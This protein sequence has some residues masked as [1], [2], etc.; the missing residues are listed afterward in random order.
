VLAIVRAEIP[1]IPT[2]K[3]AVTGRF[4]L[5][6]WP[7]LL[8]AA[9]YLLTLG[10]TVHGR[11]FRTPEAV[12]VLTA[13]AVWAMVGFATLAVILASGGIAAAWHA[14]RP[15]RGGAWDAVPRPAAVDVA[16]TGAA[17]NQSA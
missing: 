12:L 7:H 3:E 2:A 10:Y 14:R 8:L 6:A 5:L 1:Y 11:L 17:G 16:A 4:L 13:E 9:V 15:P